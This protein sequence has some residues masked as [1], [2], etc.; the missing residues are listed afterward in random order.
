MYGHKKEECRVGKSEPKTNPKESENTNGSERRLPESVVTESY[1]KWMIAKKPSRRIG[2]SEVKR[3]APE[4][5]QP[6]I[7]HGSKAPKAS[8]K[9]Q[10]ESSS[11]SR[12]MALNVHYDNCEADPKDG[13]NQDKGEG[14]VS[15]EAF[16][17]KKTSGPWWD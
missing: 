11:G 4:K 6:K 3:P 8:A 12:F 15:R 10:A 9:S 7:S 17:K 5:N 13:E 14:S 2:K 16:K 1:G